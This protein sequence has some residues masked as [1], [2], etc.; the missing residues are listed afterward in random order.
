M[1]EWLR[2]IRTDRGLTM[3]SVADTL[4]ISESYYCSIENG[5][6]Q[7]KMD[8]TVIWGLSAALSIPITKVVD[9]ESKYFEQQHKEVANGKLGN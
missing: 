4:G 5:D 6:R 1:R 9:F 8:M 3:K 2:Q 7:K